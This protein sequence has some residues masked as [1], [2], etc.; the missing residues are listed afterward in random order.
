MFRHFFGALC[1]FLLLGCLPGIS[2]SQHGHHSHDRLHKRRNVTDASDSDSSAKHVVEEA[3]KALRIA[4]K[5][6]VENMQLNKWEFQDDKSHNRDSSV[7]PLSDYSDPT[8]NTSLAQLSKR[9]SSK[10][11]SSLKSNP[12]YGYTLSPEIVKAAKE[13]AESEKPAPWDV[14]YASIASK[15]R[16]KWSSGNNDT[17]SM[18][19]KLS[20]SNGL[21][22]Y[23]TFEQPDGLQE[24]I[25]GVHKRAT[26]S[27]W[28]ADVEQNGASPYAETGY[29]V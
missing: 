13:V 5:L 12:T 21:D 11:P 1:L 26:S 16:T 2:A 19:Q 29:K 7:V 22:K 8:K 28:M 15:I 9:A 18:V 4:N 23:T 10:D 27:Y 20:R 6:R 24:P 3:L 14:D 25:Q 17:N